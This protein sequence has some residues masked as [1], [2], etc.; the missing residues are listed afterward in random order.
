MLLLLLLLLMIKVNQWQA[1]PDG[2]VRQ[3]QLSGNVIIN[4]F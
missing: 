1:M 3:L 2:V 4:F